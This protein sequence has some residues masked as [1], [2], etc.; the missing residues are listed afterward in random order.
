[1]CD[2]NKGVGGVFAPPVRELVRFLF[3]ARRR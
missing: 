1:M 2:V 3:A